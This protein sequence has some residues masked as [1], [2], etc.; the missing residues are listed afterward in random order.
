[1]IDLY[2]K[3]FETALEV[4]QID[5]F[6]PNQCCNVV[7]CSYYDL[8]QYN[9]LQHDFGDKYSSFNVKIH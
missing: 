3:A 2:H 8:A 6:L 7:L 4:T 9:I 5:Y 1:M